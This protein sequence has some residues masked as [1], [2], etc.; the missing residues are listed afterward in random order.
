MFVGVFSL[1]KMR[2]SGK[3]KT[4]E[5][6]KFCFYHLWELFK[7][8]IPF[9]T[10]LPN[11]HRSFSI[12]CIKKNDLFIHTVENF[13]EGHIRCIVIYKKKFVFKFYWR[14]FYIFI[15][16]IKDVITDGV[17]KFLWINSRGLRGYIFD[18]RCGNIKMINLS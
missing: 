8:T 9:L 14:L 7:K 6:S 18:F 3:E 5:L 16:V 4:M 12:F 2:Q 17:A 13:S 10:Y 11:C 1:L 15:I